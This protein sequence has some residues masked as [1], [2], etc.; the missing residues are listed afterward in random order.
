MNQQQIERRREIPVVRPGQPR[1]SFVP[2][3]ILIVACL[4]GMSGCTADDIAVEYGRRGGVT[5]GTSV[6][7]TG[8][9]A[10][11]FRQAGHRVTTLRRITPRLR[12]FEVVVW[13]PDDFH[14][15]SADQRVALENWLS[16]GGRTL[17]YVGRDFD[18]AP[19]Y[20]ESILPLVPSAQ[21]PE[22][23]TRMAESR[24]QHDNR[25]LG[26]PAELET[27][28]FHFERDRAPRQVSEISSSAGWLEGIAT[29]ELELYLE[30][31]LTPPV[32]G[33]EI[34]T[35]VSTPTRLGVGSISLEDELQ[36][37]E[38][39]EADLQRRAPEKVEVLL[40]ADGA[41]LVTRLRD[42]AWS[43]SQLLV[44]ANGSFLLNF[45]LLNREHRKL[46]GRIIDECG[47]GRK[48]AFLETSMMD[49]VIRGW[50]EA[51]PQP[52]G[53]EAFT[54]W[55]LGFILMQAML[56]G[57]VLCFVLFPI[58][59]PPRSL[60]PAGLSDF[61]KHVEAFGRLLERTR[62]VAFAR[63]L[64]QSHQAGLKSER[65]DT[66]DTSV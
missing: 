23:L 4:A 19:S 34:S 64:V 35:T 43:D 44:A 30:S 45:P 3:A 10:G 41:A 20:W 46:A 26:S 15:P 1:P 54:T 59:G 37:F 66:S 48:V 16:L 14:P 24:A 17:I 51:N 53:L 47:A 8:V 50:D 42:T 55:P 38:S 2:A 36:F 5:W 32:P 11:M 22:V 27:R 57:L 13:A 56:L 12:Q 49:R 33:E 63:E 31:R 61:G 58:F 52:T 9:L 21:R 18:A 60:E 25:R 28:W 65:A 39:D 29:P 40:S 6:N 7:G 62:D